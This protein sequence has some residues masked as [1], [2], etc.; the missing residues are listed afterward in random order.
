MRA[1]PRGTIAASSQTVRCST[2]AQRDGTAWLG[3]LAARTAL[4]VCIPPRSHDRFLVPSRVRLPT[5]VRLAQALRPHVTL[6]DSETPLCCLPPTAADRVHPDSTVRQRA[7]TRRSVHQVPYRTRLATRQQMSLLMCLELN[8]SGV[9]FPG[10]VCPPATGALTDNNTCNAPTSY[11]PA[12]S[13]T[14]TATPDGHYA[15]ATYFGS[16]LYFAAAMCGPGSYCEAGVRSE[17]APGRFGSDS[18]L[19]TSS[20]SGACEQGYYCVAGS[21]NATAAPCASG[22]QRYCPEVRKLSFCC[23]LV[24]GVFADHTFR[25][26]L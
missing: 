25:C 17:C 1:A 15:V 21:T 12:R 13:S 2:C 5:T 26:D 4:R 8:I 22:S 6:V 23:A 19:S 9:A 18:G 11:C 3:G 24:E 14:R 7:P 16:P 10:Y 20:C